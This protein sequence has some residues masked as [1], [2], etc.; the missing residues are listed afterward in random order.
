MRSPNGMTLGDQDVLGISPLRERKKTG[1]MASIPPH[2]KLTGKVQIG[3]RVVAAA[4]KTAPNHWTVF[5]PWRFQLIVGRVLNSG[6]G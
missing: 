6:H 3:G 5:Q 1:E 2:G 4:R